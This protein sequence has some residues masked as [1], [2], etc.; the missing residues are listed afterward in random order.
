M[1]RL[2]ELAGGEAPKAPVPADLEGWLTERLKPILNRLAALERQ[3]AAEPE[4][5][6]RFDPLADLADAEPAPG[7]PDWALV[8]RHFRR[9]GDP[10]KTAAKYGL[11]APRAERPRQ[12][13]GV[14]GMIEIVRY[15]R[16]RHWA[17]YVDGELLVVA[18]YRKGAQAVADLILQPA[19][20]KGGGPC[21]V[22]RPAARSRPPASSRPAL[23]ISWGRRARWRR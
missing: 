18:V 16:S 1:G 9:Y 17:V 6:A 8:K 2:A 10:A 15:R 11:N 13:G 21:R 5:P 14:G 12:K 4:P 3:P 23:R 22:A 7:E 20:R 19:H